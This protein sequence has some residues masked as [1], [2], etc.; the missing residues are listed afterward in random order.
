MLKPM[1]KDLNGIELWVCIDIDSNQEIITFT[2]S[3]KAQDYCD[4]H[5]HL[6]ENTYASTATTS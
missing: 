4:K 5:N 3:E 1:K 6:L 2:S